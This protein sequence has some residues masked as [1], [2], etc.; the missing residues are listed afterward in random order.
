MWC[1]CVF[2]SNFLSHFI[3]ERLHRLVIF[4]QLSAA[5]LESL[6]AQKDQ[7]GVCLSR[8]GLKKYL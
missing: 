6:N 4:V 8:F 2:F 3:L 5:S 1:D 7:V